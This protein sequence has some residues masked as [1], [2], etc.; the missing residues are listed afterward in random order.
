MTQELGS[1]E[2]LGQEK[3]WRTRTEMRAKDDG[4]KLRN[5]GTKP[6]HLSIFNINVE[7]SSRRQH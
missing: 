3:A 5:E 7:I 6:V 1:V 4:N 2:E